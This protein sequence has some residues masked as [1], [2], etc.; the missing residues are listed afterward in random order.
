MEKEQKLNGGK[1]KWSANEQTAQ[2]Q[3]SKKSQN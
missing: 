3:K 1:Y 2:P